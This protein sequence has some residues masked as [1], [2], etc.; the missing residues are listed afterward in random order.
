MHDYEY[1][2]RNMIL[3]INTLFE[4]AK[5]FYHL[6][7]SSNSK[8][9][10]EEVVVI[11]VTGIIEIFSIDGR[12]LMLL[13]E[14]PIRNTLERFKS[15]QLYQDVLYFFSDSEIVDIPIPEF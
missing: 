1:D 5:S 12:S 9:S 10:L 14:T 4:V 15:I 8:Y 3:E 13:D 7:I 2:V 6:Q 11:Y